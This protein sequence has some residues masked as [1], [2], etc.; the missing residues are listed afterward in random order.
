MPILSNY[1]TLS[2]RNTHIKYLLISSLCYFRERAFWPYCSY[3]SIEFNFTHGICH[4][5]SSTNNWVF[6]RIKQHLIIFTVRLENVTKHKLYHLIILYRLKSYLF[7]NL[8]SFNKWVFIRMK[9][10]LI[11]DYAIGESCKI[12]DV[13]FINIYWLQFYSWHLPYFF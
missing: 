11:T 5:L 3:P 6:I 12:Q 7:Q 9:Q 13:F 8:S 1:F 10:Y 4:N 2:P